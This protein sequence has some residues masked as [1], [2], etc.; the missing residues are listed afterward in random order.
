LSAVG[1]SSRERRPVTTTIAFAAL[2]QDDDFPEWPPLDESFEAAEF[3]DVQAGLDDL[4]VVVHADGHLPV[5]FDA[6]DRIDDEFAHGRNL[7]RT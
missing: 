6:R 7:S 5:A 1:V 2:H 3:D 4:V